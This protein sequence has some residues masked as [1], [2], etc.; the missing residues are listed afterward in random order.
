M[1]GRS[2][3][4]VTSRLSSGSKQNMVVKCVGSGAVLAGFVCHLY[5]NREKGPSLEEMPP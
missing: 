2:L 4:F 1:R 3:E 5:R